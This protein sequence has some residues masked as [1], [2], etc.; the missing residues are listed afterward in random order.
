MKRAPLI[1]AGTA[2]ALLLL[3]LAPALIDANRYRDDIA[4]QLERALGRPVTIAGP[5]GFSLLPVPALTAEKVSVADLATAD[6]L[7]LHLAWL[8][9]LGGRVVADSLEVRNGALAGE[10]APLRL[11][12]IDARIDT[13]GPFAAKGSAIFQGIPVTFAGRADARGGPARL[14]LALPAAGA[15]AELSGSIAN[16]RFTG[17][18]TFSAESLAPGRLAGEAQVTATASEAS[19]ADLAVS[20]GP[21]RATGSAAAAFD[22]TPRLDVALTVPS[23]DLDA[24][25]V[26]APPKPAASGAGSPARAPALRTAG[27]TFRLPTGVSADARLAVDALSWRGQVIRQARLDAT[28]DQGEVTITRAQ[29]ALPGGTTLAGE[30]TLAVQAGQPLFEGSLRAASADLR[31]V[32]AW[33][34]VEPE[35]IAADRLHRFAAS[36]TVGAAPGTVTLDDIDL[37]V[38]AVRARGHAALHDDG[39]RPSYQLALTVDSLDLD[40]YLPAGRSP[41]PK[42]APA[43]S[44]PSAPAPAQAA[45][46][47]LDAR[48]DLSFRHLTVRGSE[49]SGLRLAGTYDGH[50]ADLRA[51][52]GALRLAGTLSG[53]REA[54]TVANLDARFGAARVTG[55]AEVA[56]AGKPAVTAR[57]AANAIDLGALMRRR[58]GMPA[59]GGRL[60]PVV[61]QPVVPAALGPG[62]PWPHEPLNL[63]MLNAFNASIDFTAEALSWESWRLDAAR[64]HL[65]IT[66]GTAHLDKLTGRLLDGDAV[67]DLSVT[68][69]GQ[70]GGSV[71][72]ANVDVGRLKPGGG[73]IRLTQGR[74]DGQAGFATSGRSPADMAA[75]LGGD[76]RILVKDG[77][78]AGFDLPAVNRQLGNLSNLG[79]LLG[80]A[81]AGMS[82]GATRF[83]AL[84][85]TFHGENGVVST[86]DARLDADGGTGTA[87]GAID[88]ARWTIASRVE[89]RVA[90]GSAPPLA[91]RFDGPLDNPRKVVDVN[92]LQRYLV[93]RGLG[94]ALGTRNGDGTSER[95]SG[96]QILQD[97]LKGLGGR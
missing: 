24:W 59:R 71:T 21:A 88:L 86:R 69:G 77:V 13:T 97:L 95:P 82:G 44:A 11:E 76:G 80:V 53:N 9:L 84:T 73:Q 91:L 4:G 36:A 70:A 45:A 55:S 54:V 1:A 40:G 29:A 17:R 5:I 35:G 30:G 26:P 8:P 42:A 72:V 83:S 25:P 2:V 3:L 96:R 62:A 87:T 93:A 75:R 49:I 51:E 56:L 33:L 67:L 60:P 61:A 81:Q 18:L 38:D 16:A 64:G 52:S 37:T 78:V 39:S 92:E 63:A 10:A 15:R 89:L 43:P 85:A 48:F 50:Q 65:A 41:A 47:G 28:L 94:T 79:N 12:A 74:L 46:G 6:A 32:L 7:R 31:A 20:L 27:G 34:G 66:D 19:L 68:H 57:L 90:G 23:L 14:E 58:T 22:G